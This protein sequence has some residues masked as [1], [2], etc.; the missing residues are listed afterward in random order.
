MT[1]LSI[2]EVKND[3]RLT[4]KISQGRLGMGFPIYYVSY[5]LDQAH[6]FLE[7]VEIM[8]A[9]QRIHSLSPNS[10]SYDYS[11]RRLRGILAGG[12]IL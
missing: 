11:N 3:N 12:T 4:F 7:K 1:C 9:F 8:P 6:Y 5:E 2:K 10:P